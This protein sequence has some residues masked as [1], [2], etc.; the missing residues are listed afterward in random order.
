MVGDTIFYRGL[1]HLPRIVD[2][3]LVAPNYRVNVFGWTALQE[4]AAA[5]PR[6]VAGNYGITDL[7]VAL[8]WVQ[9]NAAAFGCDPSRV[10]IYGQSSGGTNIFALLASQ[11]ARGLFHGAIS[12]SGSPNL[13]SDATFINAK[14][15]PVRS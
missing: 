10:V 14:Q 11:A 1:D 3:C 12:L 6:G 2:A 4:L 13:T 9:D 7:L 15:R 8:R 5:D